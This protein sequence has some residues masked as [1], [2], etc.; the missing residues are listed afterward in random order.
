[1]RRPPKYDGSFSRGTVQSIWD[2]DGGRCA[3]C[4]TPVA[5]ERGLNW[6]VHH[7]QPRGMGGTAEAY[8]GR[9]SN[10]VLLHGSGTTACHGY[11]EAHRQEAEDKGFLVSRNGVE[12]PANVAIEH[13]VHGRCRLNDDGTVTRGVEVF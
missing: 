8:V 12:R 3:W 2:R 1:M 10:G 13:A 11:L 6:S 5:G 9:A 7:R 4:G